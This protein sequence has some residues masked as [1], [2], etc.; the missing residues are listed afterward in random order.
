MYRGDQIRNEA[1]ELVLYADTAT[2]LTA[3]IALNLALFY[4]SCEEGRYGLVVKTHPHASDPG[5]IP[6]ATLGGQAGHH[7]TP[8]AGKLWQEFLSVKLRQLGGVESEL[9]PS[10]GC[11]DAMVIH[12]F[13]TYMLMI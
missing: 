13:S 12:C 2:T 6:A 10:I 11:F 5:S 9:Y 8:L 1:N 7:P 3:L 4:G